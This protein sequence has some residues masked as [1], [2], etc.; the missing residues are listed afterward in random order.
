MEAVDSF[1][2]SYEAKLRSLNPAQKQLSYTVADVHKYIDGMHDMSMMVF[3]PQT[4]QYAPRGK[5][6]LK[7]QIMNRLKGAAK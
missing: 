3:D 4:T 5:P 6:F 2:S 7:S 1:I